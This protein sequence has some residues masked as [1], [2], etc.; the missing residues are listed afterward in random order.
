MAGND[1]NQAALIR[2]LLARSGDASGGAGMPF[3]GLPF[4]GLPQL[5]KASMFGTDFSQQ[6]QPRAM[7]PDAPIAPPPAIPAMD[8]VRTGA[9]LGDGMLEKALADLGKKKEPQDDGMKKI[10]DAMEASKNAL[11][12][13]YNTPTPSSEE[14]FTQGP[15]PGDMF[16]A[17]KPKKKFYTPDQA[18]EGVMGGVEEMPEMAGIPAGYF[19]YLRGQESG[20]NDKAVNKESKAAG[21]YQFLEGTVK[22]LVSRVPGLAGKIDENWR[23]DGN[24]QEALLRAYTQLSLDALKPI[25]K[26]R[27]PTMGE[28]YAMHFFGHGGGYTALSNP[29]TPIGQLFP[30]I[31]FK[32]NPKLSRNLTGSQFVQY[33]N[34][35]W[36]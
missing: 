32:Q 15:A 29:N 8:R 22:D 19:N 13:L 1:E 28:L 26:D 2:M 16:F 10:R 25:V 12:A 20:G 35:A 27:M 34:N 7:A 3:A 30:D 31:V 17:N 5:P 36:K 6:Q 24:Q 18:P 21:R 33:I 4:S 11:A 23:T 14:G 9:S